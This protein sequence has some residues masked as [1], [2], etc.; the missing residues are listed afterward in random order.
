MRKIR[1]MTGHIINM[2]KHFKL[3]LIG[4]SLTAMINVSVVYADMIAPNSNSHIDYEISSYPIF[5]DIGYIFP[6]ILLLLIIVVIIYILYHIIR[7]I[8]NEIYK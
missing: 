8:I 5:Q 4:I 1:M 7:A 6:A 3:F 2:A